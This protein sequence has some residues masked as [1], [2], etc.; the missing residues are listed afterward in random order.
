MSSN[1]ESGRRLD[2]G[3]NLGANPVPAPSPDVNRIVAK[4][5]HR[6]V[7]QVGIGLALLGWVSGENSGYPRLI[8][9][10][11][12]ALFAW[13]GTERWLEFSWVEPASR[14]DRSD[15]RMQGMAI[16][17]S[18]QPERRWRA[19]FSVRRRGFWPLATWL[20]VMLAT[21]M[22]RLPRLRGL[23]IGAVALDL[24]LMAQIALIALCAFGAT[25]TAPDPRWARGA[26]IATAFFNSPV[27]TYSLLFALWAWFANPAKGIDLTGVAGLVRR[28]LGL[29][30]RKSSP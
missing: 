11:A 18:G 14:R 17:P 16:G 5:L 26:A 3:E 12:N 1:P 4:P 25:Q 19:V 7:L 28:R 30:R 13:A 27:P 21:P 23:A 29:G 22:S 10:Q 24:L 2:S 8:H 9:A 15:T 20:A 6:F